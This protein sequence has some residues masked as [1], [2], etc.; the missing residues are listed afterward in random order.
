MYRKFWVNEHHHNY[1]KVLWR[2]SSKEPLKTYALT[3]VNF[4]TSSAPFL[5][6]TLLK[7]IAESDIALNFPLSSKVVKLDFYVDD[8]VL[9]SYSCEEVIDIQWQVRELLS[10][11]GFDETDSF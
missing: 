6:I 11:F 2:F 10:N 7:Y 5:A 1:Q 9:G 4:G 3:T 8:L